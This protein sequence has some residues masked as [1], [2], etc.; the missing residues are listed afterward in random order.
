MIMYDT[1][2]GKY[3]GPKID[4]SKIDATRAWFKHKENEAV[5]K[6]FHLNGSRLEKQ[7]AAEELIICERKLRYWE[8]AP[9]FDKDEAIRM[10]A[11]LN[12]DWSNK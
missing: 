6:F 10:V 2:P 5:L 9:N 8:H 4:L 1:N 7:E 11:K 3:E 12:K